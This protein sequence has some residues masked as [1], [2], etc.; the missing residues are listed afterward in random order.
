MP[1]ILLIRNP[2]VQPKTQ[3]R[4]NKVK[5][6]V[7]IYFVE[8]EGNKRDV[9]NPLQEYTGR[10]RWQ[11]IERGDPTSR[12]AQAVQIFLNISKRTCNRNKK[13]IP[14]DKCYSV[15]TRAENNN[16][17]FLIPDIRY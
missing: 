2:L 17:L 13:Y 12:V 4:V 16:T 11:L 9:L 15:A 5:D 10:I 6:T 8:R 14:V 1:F 3:R 7:K